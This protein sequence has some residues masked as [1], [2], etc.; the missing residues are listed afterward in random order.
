MHELLVDSGARGSVLTIWGDAGTGKSALLLEVGRQAEEMGRL[1]LRATGVESEARMPFAGLHQLTRPV[2]GE[3]DGLATGQREAMLEAF[4]STGRRPEVFLVA[5]AALNLMGDIAARK[6]VAV[7]VDDGQW[8]DRATLEV[9]GFIARRLQADPVA[10]VMS[11][12]N[13]FD[14]PLGLAG[15]PAVNLEALDDPAATELLDASFPALTQRSRELVLQVA[16]GNPLALLE[17]PAVVE[18]IPPD[19][20]TDWLPLTN[21]L[22]QAFAVRMLDLPPTTRWLLLVLAMDD[23]PSAG[24]VLAAT[25]AL[26][27]RPPTLDDLAPAEGARLIAI[28]GKDIRF[29]HPLMRSAVRQAATTA[30]RHTVHAALAE[31]LADD[32]DRSVWHRAAAAVAPD[33]SVAAQLE[34]TAE[35]LRQR[36]E[37]AGAMTALARAAELTSSPA[38]KGA[39]LVGAAE[40][41][42]ELGRNQDVV[43][44]V[45]EAE[46]LDLEMRT[47][48]SILWLRE[49]LAES[50]GTGSVE[51]MTKVAE[52]LIAE[53]E[54][55]L[56]L[57]ALYTAAV[58]CYMFRVD[59]DASLMVSRVAERLDLPDGDPTL[60][61]IHAL[62]APSEWRSRIVDEARGR[63]PEELIRGSA[64]L[65]TAMDALH[66]YA[67]ALTCVGEFRMGVVFQ[68]AAIA[69]LR[70]QGRLGVLARA[71]G[72]HAVGRLVLAD[73]E[74]ANQAADECLRLSGYVRGAPGAPTDGERILNTGSALLV[75]GTIAGNRGQHDLAEALVADAVQVVGSIGSNFCLA[76]IQSAR[77]SLALAVGRSE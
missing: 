3:V 13:G 43:E 59:G 34:V 15:A 30:E 62:A 77:A 69:G 61:A 5:L 63:T 66:V 1:V 35:A 27:E 2:I 11:C 14:D 28:D 50:S 16:A 42:L 65:A 9:L 4:G 21:R 18:R 10:L 19:P 74:L 41:A 52:Q 46:P 12:R 49:A 26:V 8:L 75:L 48:H 23:R 55:R 45:D 67:I 60:A 54:P 72:S 32:P 22:E 58:R 68:D 38:R 70:T 37:T 64:D 24:E 76:H 73:W 6:P 33:E 20:G 56:A 53:G 29:R 17:L 51:S 40:L 71:L 25:A 31:V 47:R 44:L 57:H 39:R 36:H 7:L